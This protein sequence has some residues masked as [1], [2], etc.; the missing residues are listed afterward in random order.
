[1]SPYLTV[2]VLAVSA[3]AAALPSAAQDLAALDARS[4][5]VASPAPGGTLTPPST[6]AHG[7]VVA[8]FL[9]SRGTDAGTVG[10]LRA[11]T[12]RRDAQTGLSQITLRQEV[13]GL[14]VYGTYVRASLNTRGELVHLIENLA[15]VSPAG[16]VRARVDAAQALRAALLALYP[17]QAV[18]PVESARS[19]HTTAFSA[20]AFFDRDPTVTAV[21]LPMTDNVLRAGFLVETWSRAT[22]QLDQTVVGGDGRVLL[23]ESRTNQDKFKVFIEDPEKDG[24]VVVDG[25]GTTTESPNGWLAGSQTTA[26]IRGNNARAYLDADNNNQPDAGGATVTD[27]QFL[28]DADLLSAPTAA[29]NRNV[30]VQNLFYLNN[31]IHD[32]LYRHGFDEAAGNF[33]VDNFGRGGTGNDAVNAE[34]QDGGGVD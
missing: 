8:E 14:Q 24:Q 1:M 18:T 16:V 4:A 30:A 17:G 6:A 15:R 10:S 12:S 27:G 34:A 7:T 21:A 23:V 13:E 5:R 29:S 28:T 20:G 31:R 25:P 26:N 22:N 32:L 2:T 33:Q 3:L 19:G 11:V 9:Q